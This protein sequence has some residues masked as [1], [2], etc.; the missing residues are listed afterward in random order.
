MEPPNGGYGWICTACVALINA[1]TWGLNSSY[2]VFL[3]HYLANDTYPGATSLQFALIGSLSISLSMLV[4][5]LATICTR[6]YGTRVTLY[7]GVVLEAASLICAS[8]STRIWQLFLTQGVLFGVSMGFLFVPSAGVIPQWFTSKRSL[9]NGIASAGSGMGGLLYALVSGVAMRRLGV[10]WTYRILGIV[11]FVVT[12]VCSA[13][14]R[15]RHAAVGSSQN[16]FD[17]RILRR[18][19]YGLLAAFGWFSILGYIVLIF[20]LANYANHIGLSASD[21]ALVSAMLNMGQGIGR[22]LIGYFSDVSGR[23]NMALLM[24]VA[25]GV[26]V[27]GVWIPAKSLGVLV[28]FAIC[29][30]AVAGTFWATIPPVTAEVVELADVPSALNLMWLLIVPPAMGSEMIAMQIV[31]STGRYIGAQVFV[32]SM[33]MAAAVSLIMLRGWKIGVEEEKKGLGRGEKGLD[34]GETGLDKGE[35]VLAGEAEQAVK[36][37]SWGNLLRLGCT[38]AKV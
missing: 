15:D 35:K 38:P 8:F 2:G 17:T 27:F 36:Q 30:G 14:V 13:L 37:V 12:A 26:L 28:F 5:P 23:I 34:S 31:A 4:S 16:A 18:F 19:E 9:A 24:T 10:P 20:S 3:A 29:G 6:K 1:H 21:G 7:I 22:P 11:S 25:C 33:Y 32:G